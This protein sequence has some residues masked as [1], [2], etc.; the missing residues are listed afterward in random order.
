[1]SGSNYNYIFTTA[2]KALS[3]DVVITPKTLTAADGFVFAN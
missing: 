3:S 2:S 1:M